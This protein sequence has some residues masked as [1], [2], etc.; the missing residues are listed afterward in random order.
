MSSL[1]TSYYISTFAKLL[2]IKVGENSKIRHW[3]HIWIKL[4]QVR[5][6]KARRQIHNLSDLSSS[7][8]WLISIAITSSPLD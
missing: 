7:W 3:K 1:T 4:L 8:E 6:H 2:L 5:I